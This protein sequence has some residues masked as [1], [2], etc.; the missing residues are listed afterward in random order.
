[1]EDTIHHKQYRNELVKL[2]HEKGISDEKVLESIR[3]VP[4][5]LFIEAKLSVK[6]MYEDEPIGIG[7]GQT[8]SQPFTV[9]WQTQLLDIVSG[10]KI[11]EIGTGSGYQAAVL[12]IMGAE[13][14]TIERQKK[15]YDETKKRITRL[16]YSQI[17]LFYGDGNRGLPELA[18]FDKILVTAAAPSI[19]DLLVE[20]LR[21]GGSLVVP[22]NGGL[23]RM[24]KITKLSETETRIED[25]GHFRF[26]PLLP[27]TE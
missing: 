20:Q 4:R 25:H 14:F 2:L 24:L 19:P 18:P 13:V 26:V 8:I 9:A 5:H 7:Q 27:G 16:G 23:Q 17:H 10:D 22:V 3:R 6:D 15:L 11:L 12:Y 1:M 21:I